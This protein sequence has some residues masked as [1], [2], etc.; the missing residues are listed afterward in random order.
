MSSTDWIK[1]LA[2]MIGTALFSRWTKQLIGTTRATVVSVDGGC[3][4]NPEVHSPLLNALC[5][6]ADSHSNSFPQVSGLFRWSSPSAIT[7]LVVSVNVNS[8]YG[9]FLRRFVAHRLEKFLKRVPLSAH[10]YSSSAVAGVFLRPWVFA[11]SKHHAPASVFR[12]SKHSVG[13]AT[14]FNALGVVAPARLGMAFSKIGGIYKD[15][16][17]AIAQALPKYVSSWSNISVDY[18]EAVKSL[19][20]YI[21]KFA[22][23]ALLNVKHLMGHGKQRCGCDSGATLA[24][25]RAF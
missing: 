10:G 11:S 16:F 13:F 19:P 3:V 21:N 5:F 15:G 22:H 24:M 1:T 4:L 17:T 18:G 12:S 23:S 6:R 9:V 8:V 25:Q 14:G 2:P 20:S 7:R